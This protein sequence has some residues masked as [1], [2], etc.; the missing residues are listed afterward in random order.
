MKNFRLIRPLVFCSFAFLIF[1]FSLFPG[2]KVYRFQDITVP[3]SIRTIK[4]NFIENHASYVNPQFSPALTDKL[5]QKIT[6]Q[7]KLS[8]TNDEAKADWVISGEVT[9]Y[10]TST[11][12][13][14]SQNGKSTTSINRLNISIKI[15][16]NEA[17]K[18]PVDYTVSRQFDYPSNQPL[19]AAEA[20][21]LDEMIRGLTD[22][23]F[24]RLFSEW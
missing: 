14:T 17:N 11:S 19:Q 22:D 12:G 7:T 15:T 1:S 3:D 18:D 20:V 21:L 23:I 8:Q 5:K 13:V 16:K 9:E 4:I 24:N 6:S 2:C 10:Y